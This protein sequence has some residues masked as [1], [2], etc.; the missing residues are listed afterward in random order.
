MNIIC[1]GSPPQCL[2]EA[3]R[4]KEVLFLVVETAAGASH[5]GGDV[6]RILGYGDIS[7][8]PLS[9]SHGVIWYATFTFGEMVISLR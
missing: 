3:R 8:L 6:R 7:L 1:K 4:G 5:G 2:S 9:A